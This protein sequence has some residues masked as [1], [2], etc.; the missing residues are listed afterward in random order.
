MAR[1]HEAA[2]WLRK[3]YSPSRIARE[4]DVTVSTIM[5][6]LYN[7]VGEGKIRRSDIVFS[8]DKGLRDAVESVISEIRRR[9]PK[10]KPTYWESHRIWERLAKKGADANED[11][12]GV[13]LSLRDAR[14]ALGDMYEY[15]RETELFLHDY[16]RDVLSR[17]YGPDSW[18]REGVPVKIR[19]ECAAARE[20]DYEAADDP[21]RYTNFIH[22]K[23]IL[24]KN[25]DKFSKILPGEVASD[26]RSLLS[27]L[28]KLNRIR[29][30][31]M[32]P[33]RANTPTEEDFS[34]VRDFAKKLRL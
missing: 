25:W 30:L 15:I 34:F 11:D 26:R 3:G 7:Q 23:E 1:K 18:W 8:I 9:N 33:V 17:G 2:D 31:V 22:L 32:H 4:M 13:Y 28:E 29:N 24:E 20:E 10:Y 27:N 16:I 5:Q 14:V 19:K 21:F 12:V 6:Y